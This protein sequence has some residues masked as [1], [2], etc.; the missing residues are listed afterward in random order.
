MPNRREI[1]QIGIA[2]TAWPLAS[3]AVRAAG[4]G[5]EDP[6]PLYRVI[7]DRRF[8]DSVEFARRAE[9]LGLPTH[10]IEGDMTRF[11]YDDLYHQW[12]RGPVAIAGLTA[13]GPMFCFEQLGRDQGM[14]LVF[15]AEHRLA[16]DRVDHDFLGPTS[17]LA[18]SARV[19]EAGPRWSACM[20]DVVARCPSGRAELSAARAATVTT[21]GLGNPGAAPLYTW[22]VAPARNA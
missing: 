16:E 9:A 5:S 14:K 8:G 4:S 11:W 21:G 3:Q 6:V 7:Y 10:A 22:V 12:Q 20:A 17:M 1:L 13:H 2:A 19:R 18:G 15:R